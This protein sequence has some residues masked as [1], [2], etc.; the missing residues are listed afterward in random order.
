MKR[1]SNRQAL[2]IWLIIPVSFFAII[3]L[4]NPS[5]FMD[6]MVIPSMVVLVLLCYLPLLSIKLI[7]RVFKA[8]IV[9]TISIFITFTLS[10]ISL[11]YLAFKSDGQTAIALILAPVYLVPVAVCTY[12]VIF[13]V[14]RS[15]D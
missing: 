13:V 1:L 2:V 7:D 9:Y 12:L 10:I 8:D 3:A 5:G 6:P 15:L 14:K 11:L 4:R